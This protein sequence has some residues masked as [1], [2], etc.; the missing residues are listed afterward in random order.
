MAKKKH[1]QHQWVCDSQTCQQV[2][3]AQR[4]R[5]GGWQ[6][7]LAHQHA[8]ASVAETL[9]ELHHRAAALS[10]SHK[11]L[12]VAGGRLDDNSRCDGTLRHSTMAAPEAVPHLRAGVMVRPQ[13]A[14]HKSEAGI[15]AK[16]LAAGRAADL[17]H[18]A[19]ADRLSSGSDSQAA[20]DRG[21]AA[22]AVV[23]SA[24]PAPANR[25][26]VATNTAI[27]HD[28]QVAGTTKGWQNSQLPSQEL[29]AH[30][31]ETASGQVV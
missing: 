16:A 18:Q 3:I 23:L 7:W 19:V 30:Y 22:L 15:R 31:A 17:R 29:A 28:R 2:L 5:G 11:L 4:R 1:R 27:C 8:T 6:C 10:G 25:S 20:G 9:A 24:E 21:E 14:A 26:G 13:L 12:P